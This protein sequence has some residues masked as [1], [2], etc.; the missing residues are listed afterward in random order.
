[1]TTHFSRVRFIMT[2]PSHP[3]NVGSASRAIKTMGF[4][5]LVLVAPK[6]PDI[7]SQPEAIALASGAVDVLNNAPILGTLDQ[8]LAPVTLSF[9]LTARSRDL[10]PSVCDIREAAHFAKEHL[11]SHQEARVALVVGT[12]RSG[13]T[14]E[15]IGL[16]HRVCHIPANP[17]YSSLNVS[18]AMQLAAWEM[19]YALLQAE[20][21]IE[22]GLP[23]PGRRPASTES[24]L[25]LIAHWQ[26]AL[27]AVEFLNPAYP[28]K[29]IPRMRH[30]F[31]RN[32]L[33]QDEVDMMRGVCS[34]MIQ[35]AR[36]GRHT[37]YVAP[38]ST[39]RS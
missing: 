2:E 12:E 17:E 19:R 27:E 30:L 32:N 9:A 1:M 6:T 37:P 35:T 28:K 10:G 29:L 23:P 15:Q 8:A 7:S 39:L 13:L 36:F 20:P 22:E 4:H 26:E 31:S 34:A 14:N 3:G 38:S 5:D 33:T 21:V 11:A 25:A 18:Q 24:V 16:C